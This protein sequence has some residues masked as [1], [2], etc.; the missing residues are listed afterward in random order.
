[1]SKPQSIMVAVTGREIGHLASDS[2]CEDFR[3]DHCSAVL[4]IW[5][6][7]PH[8]DIFGAESGA[9]SRTRAK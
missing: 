5:S 4:W 6:P 9:I 7:N 1:M 8:T 3:I 2:Y